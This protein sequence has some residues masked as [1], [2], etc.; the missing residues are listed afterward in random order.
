M[1]E[2]VLMQLQ[3]GLV[4]EDVAD[5][6]RFPLVHAPEYSILGSKSTHKK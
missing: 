2:S 3:L 4:V 5:D 6:S 1:Q